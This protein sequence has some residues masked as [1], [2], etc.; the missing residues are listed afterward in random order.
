M[1]DKGSGYTDIPGITTV[2]TSTGTGAVLEA[3]S[4]TIGK[5]VRATIENIG[6]DYPA[7][8]TLEPSTLFPLSLIHI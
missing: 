1:F 6:F 3:S 8:L 7:D 2:T 4:K 5:V